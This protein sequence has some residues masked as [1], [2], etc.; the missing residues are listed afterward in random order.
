MGF[1]PLNP[2]MLSRKFAKHVAKGYI[3]SVDVSYTANG[4]EVQVTLP[5][6]TRMSPGAYLERRKAE[7]SASAPKG[8]EE[9]AKELKKVKDAFKIKY[10]LRLRKECPD[11]KLPSK[12]DGTK[13]AILSLEF[14]DRVK[15][16]LSDKDFQKEKS[17]S[18][19]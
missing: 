19:N 14:E 11:D 10:E 6:N 7:K 4:V 15:M 1:D 17:K 13:A 2:K 8:A 5:D 9:Q 3:K 12:I 16:L 18:G